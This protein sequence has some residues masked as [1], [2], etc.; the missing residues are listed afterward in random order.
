[1]PDQ[2]E[3]NILLIESI[4]TSLT[5]V[6]KRDDGI[7]EIRFKQDEYEVDVPDQ[8]QI[9]DACTTLTDNGRISFPLLVIPGRYGGITKEAREMEMFET[10]VFGNMK[11]MAI[12]VRA[13]HQRL[14]GTLYFSL[15][16]NKPT[17][18]YKLFDSVKNAENWLK[19]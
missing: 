15:K 4:E 11:A 8:L 18:P 10:K 19:N 2:K 13:L 6:K 1:M 12:V 9:L 17:Y 5:F 7:I 16:K 14:L 3:K